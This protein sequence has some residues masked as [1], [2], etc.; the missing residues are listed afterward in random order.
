MQQSLYF[1]NLSVTLLSHHLIHT[2]QLPMA[3]FANSYGKKELLNRVHS[4]SSSAF[5]TAAMAL[6]S[7][8]LYHPVTWPSYTDLQTTH[9]QLRQSQSKSDQY[10]IKNIYELSTSTFFT[11]ISNGSNRGI[12]TF[13]VYPNH[14]ISA[15]LNPMTT[16]FIFQVSPK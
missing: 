8:P 15:G 11:C 10:G 14:H 7:K 9:S 1:Q 5:Q 4:P 2:F 6:P 3:N 12:S 13:K 16:K